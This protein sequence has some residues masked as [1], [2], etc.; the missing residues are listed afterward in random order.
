M[1][2]SLGAQITLFI[3][4][5]SLF[6]GGMFLKVD[7]GNKFL[8][9]S[10]NAMKPYLLPLSFI[11]VIILVVILFLQIFGKETADEEM[12]YYKVLKSLFHLA[13]LIIFGIFL[14]LISAFLVIQMLDL[15]IGNSAYII[16]IAFFI[17]IMFLVGLIFKKKFEINF[18]DFTKYL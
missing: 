6:F 11:F 13:S 1:K 12:A 14:G 3:F 18:F 15:G 10:F 4:F 9:A 8:N 2:K 17:F 7:F 5:A 16:G